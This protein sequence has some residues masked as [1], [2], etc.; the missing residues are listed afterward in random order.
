MSQDIKK[1][2]TNVMVV[3]AP[4]PGSLSKTLSKTVTPGSVLRESKTFIMSYM[5]YLMAWLNVVQAD[6][7]ED[8]T[9]EIS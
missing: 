1:Y 7:D 6:E 5:T 3:I 2:N 8:D 4:S 9:S